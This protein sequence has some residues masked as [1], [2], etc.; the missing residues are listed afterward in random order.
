MKPRIFRIDPQNIDFGLIKQAAAVL[1][2]RGLVAFPTETVYG[3]GANALDPKAVAGIFE[4]KK[5]PLDDPLIVHIADI[6][7]FHRLVAEIPAVAEKLVNCFWPGPLTVILKKTALVPDIVTTGLETVAV[8]MPSGEIARSFIKAAGVPVAAPSANMFGRPSP[9]TA[10]HVIDD[11]DGR[12]DVLLDGGRT[13]IG[14]ESTVVEVVGGRI[15]VL[16]P[17]GVSVEELESVAG[18]VEVLSGSEDM[19]KSPG[20]YPCH[21]SPRARV[22]LVEDDLSQVDTVASVVAAMKEIG[23]RTAVMATQE[24]ARSYKGVDVKVLGPGNDGKICASRLFHVLREFDAE[25]VEVIVA[26]GIPEK[27]LG[28]AVM[29]RLRKAAGPS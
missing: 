7:D 20:K 9:T 4:A 14:V 22:I 11:L 1:N 26:E 16:R 8:R 3:L 10:Q 18:P 24:N 12:I 28:L 21:Y 6:E 25:K 2:N 13:D 23:K 5:R 15:V 19:L 29:N 17:G 27:G